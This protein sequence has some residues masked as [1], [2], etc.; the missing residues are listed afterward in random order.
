MGR[1]RKVGKALGQLH[2]DHE[3]QLHAACNVARGNA[4]GAAV[5]GRQ[6]GRRAALCHDLFG[7]CAS[8]AHDAA[9]GCNP[10]RDAEGEDVSSTKDLLD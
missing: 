2:L 10:P 5:V 4:R 6:T 8:E 3:R 1:E 9:C 7:V